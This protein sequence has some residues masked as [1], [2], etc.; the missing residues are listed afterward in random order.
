MSAGPLPARRCFP[1]AITKRNALNR[2]RHALLAVCCSITACHA[3]AQTSLDVVYIPRQISTAAPTTED[4]LEKRACVFTTAAP[5]EIQRIRAL[6]ESAPHTL[7]TP[8]RPWYRAAIFVRDSQHGTSKYFFHTLRDEQLIPMHTLSSGV[9]TITG[10]PL[11]VAEQIFHQ[12]PQTQYTPSP[13][14]KTKP[15]CLDF[16]PA[17]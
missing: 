9:D 15:E 17:F 1:T 10:V 14:T 5:V 3:T 13:K 11:G 12:I 8:P 6:L 7:I 2:S 16:V 4:T